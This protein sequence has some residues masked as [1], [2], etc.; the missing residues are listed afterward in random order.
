MVV[1][2]IVNPRKTV[3]DDRTGDDDE[4][5]IYGGRKPRGSIGGGTVRGRRMW[6]RKSRIAC[7]KGADGSSLA[8]AKRDESRDTGEDISVRPNPTKS[9]ISKQN[10]W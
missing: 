4:L 9:W 1:I 2:R 6:N 3:F 10:M 8:R 7:T 5:R